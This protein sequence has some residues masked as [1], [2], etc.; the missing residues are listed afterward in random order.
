MTAPTAHL[1]HPCDSYDSCLKKKQTEVRLAY[2]E[3]CQ[4]V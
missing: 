3:R 1:V 4:R 2:F